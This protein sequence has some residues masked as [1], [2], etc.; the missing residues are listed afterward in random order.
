MSYSFEVSGVLS[1][2]GRSGLFSP[3][4][5]PSF[6]TINGQFSGS[7]SL[8]YTDD[9]GQSF[10]TVANA[11]GAAPL[12]Q[13]SGIDRTPGRQWAIQALAPSGGSWSGAVSYQF[14]LP[15]WN[16]ALAHNLADPDNP[17]VIYAPGA[18]A[19]IDS[20]DLTTLWQRG[21]IIPRAV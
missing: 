17:A 16:A 15:D 2:P 12:P 7:A 6:V 10:R 5:Q 19:I 20:A 21:Y 4:G 9:N 18:R 1:A 8:Q 13:A 3:K 14:T 11:L